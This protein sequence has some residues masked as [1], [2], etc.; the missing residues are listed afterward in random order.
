MH[1]RCRVGSN[2]YVVYCLGK[3]IA[4]W[5]HN[6]VSP[7]THMCVEGYPRSA[8]TFMM[9][10][11]R[12]AE[13]KPYRYASHTHWA[14]NVLLALKLNIPV[15]ILIR[16]PFDCILSNAVFEPE[17]NL[18][19][20]IK[21]YILFYNKLIPYKNNANIVEFN[22]VTRRPNKVLLDVNKIDRC[23]FR[24]LLLESGDE[25]EA[26]DALVEKWH[27][28]RPRSNYEN[29]EQTIARPSADRD[30]MKEEYKKLIEEEQVLSR[31]MMEANRIYK[32][33][34]TSG[35]NQLEEE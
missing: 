3:F 26:V 23:N 31:L 21:D 28:G 16:E 12:Q 19:R 1:F 13:I 10:L 29:V 20:H 25:K 17:V 27:Y 8:N 30:L 5:R 9:A 33:F 11:L 7:N 22:D 34:I 24:S 18:K 6:I 14:G 4:K 35:N 15:I 32:I 2:A